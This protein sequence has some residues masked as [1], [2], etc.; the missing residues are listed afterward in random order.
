MSGGWI[1]RHGD[2]W[3]EGDDGLMHTPETAPFSREH[4]E[5]KWGPL[6]PE[7]SEEAE[8]KEREREGESESVSPD[9]IAPSKLAPAEPDA[10][11]VDASLLLAISDPGATSPRL[12]NENVTAWSAR[13]VLA[14]PW[15]AAHVSAA[16]TKACGDERERIAKAI[17]TSVSYGFGL[18]HDGSEDSHAMAYVEGLKDAHDIARGDAQ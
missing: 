16:E 3:T 18:N 8:T 11:E 14:S 5:R 2:V 4:V 15:L 9:H 13:A 1:D 6:T 7:P 17:A 10:G 12:P